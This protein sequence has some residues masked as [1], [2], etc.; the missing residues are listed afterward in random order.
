[1]TV[2]VKVQKRLAK[3]RRKIAEVQHQRQDAKAD[4]KVPA[5]FMPTSYQMAIDRARAIEDELKP[6]PV[7][8]DFF[9]P[10]FDQPVIPQ[11]NFSSAA[12]VASPAKTCCD[13]AAEAN[14]AHHSCDAAMK[15]ES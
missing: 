1:M 5:Q 14:D 3:H 9:A 12:F 10:I 2:S 13:S 7:V 6:A 15:E 8:S 4:S 11:I